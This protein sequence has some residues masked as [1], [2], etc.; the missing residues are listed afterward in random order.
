VDVPALDGVAFIDPR[1]SE[2]DIIQ[3]VGR[4][5]RLS[6]YKTMGTI[7]IPVFI[8]QTDDAKAALEASDF[9]PI[10]DVLEALKSHD[11][12]LSDELDQLRI[13]L[14]AKRKRSVGA[15][16]LT[17]I[18]F[19]LP[20][21][22]NEDFAQSLRA[23]LVAQTTESW[24]FW[25]GLLETFVKERGHCRVPQSY[26]EN[27][28]QLGAWV[29]NQRVRRNRISIERQQKLDE[30]G[31]IWDQLEAD[32]N[33]GLSYLK[34]YRERE[35]HC[36]VPH[37]YVENGYALGK[38]VSVQRQRQHVLSEER[39]Q[40]LN[41]LGFS[42]DPYEERWD[43][44]LSHLQTYKQR[45]GH[46]SVPLQYKTPDGYLLGRWVSNQRVSQDKLSDECKARLDA[47]GF[48]W[49]PLD[50]AWEDGLEHLRA[51]V[52]EHKHCQVPQ[53]YQSPDG[54]RLGSWVTGRRTRKDNL[55]PEQIEIL[56][57]LGFDWDPISAQWEEGVEHLESYVK[58]NK[59][60]RV[61][62]AYKT[63]DG[64]PLGRW[65]HRQRNNRDISA[66]RKARLDALGFDW[67]PHDTAW[68]DGLEHLR[69]FVNE[70]KHCR[71]RADYK[72]PDGYCL[73]S[74]VRTQR[75]TRETLSA[76]REARLN[77]LG[78]D[79]D[80]Y[81]DTAW[82]NG[83]EHLRAFVNEHKHC[84][85]SQ[86]YKSP[87]GFKLGT[88]V[89]KQRSKKHI[90]SSERI[91]LL[92]ALGFDWNP[93]DTA[94]E[95][96]LQ[97]LRAFVNEYKHCRVSRK[98]KSPDGYRLGSWVSNR[99]SI[100]DMLSPKQIEELDALGFDLNPHDTAWEEGVRYLTIYKER[101]GHCNVPQ[102]HKENGFPLGQWVR[103]Q[104]E[105]KDTMESDRRQ[106]LEAL[107]GW[108]WKVE[109]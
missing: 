35:G 40:R 21:S 75:K 78:F 58:E 41:E 25:Y 91:E 106:R 65:V 54:F 45:E 85:V 20:T 94:W 13:E 103:R 10:W 49:N 14:G 90:L 63:S 12:R 37:G 96:G 2:I 71:F 19:D 108:V 97:H 95:N 31:F 34:A 109:K 30:L 1:R 11:D 102:A 6:E 84:R 88:W 9:K 55:S 15:S 105:A 32:W 42:W 60:C 72:S 8:E 51:F 29:N 79:W 92:D 43:A 26:E 36:R 59:H 53:D 56:D 18:V 83:L 73:G 64:Y 39:R 100:K 48:D 50:T 46:C 38:W 66:E 98:Y 44:G 62:Q 107:P 24:M 3:S 86:Q 61:P 68:E 80:S 67:N 101:E 69:A 82:E 99:R 93:L 104:R 23:Y 7:M 57:A 77:A 22:V 47:L 17:K 70:H 4:A 28:F 74:W 16:D 27:G 76:D 89:N 52:T 5:I 81:Y 87:D 33:E